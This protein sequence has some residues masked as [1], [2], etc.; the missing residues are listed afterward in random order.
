MCLVGALNDSKE[1]AVWMDE[2][3]RQ[4][5]AGARRFVPV[6]GGVGDGLL[7]GPVFI[8]ITPSD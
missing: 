4:F 7:I 8:A 3:D 1:S 2:L 6:P 5:L